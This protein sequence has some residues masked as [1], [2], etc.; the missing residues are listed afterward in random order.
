MPEMDG[1]PLL[2][3]RL[4]DEHTRIAHDAL[5][6]QGLDPHARLID[7]AETH[8]LHEAMQ[9]VLLSSFTQVALYLYT[10]QEIAQLKR[11]LCPICVLNSYD[12]SSWIG[13]AAVYLR[14]VV[15]SAR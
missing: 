1:V 11:Q 14:E 6:A 9:I 13:R 3:L 2:D 15:E 10:E 5:S 12:F 7:P 8:E 4:C